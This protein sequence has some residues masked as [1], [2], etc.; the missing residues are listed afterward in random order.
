[1]KRELRQV[2]AVSLAALALIVW[3]ALF[4]IAPVRQI[5][6]WPAD[7]QPPAPAAASARPD[8]ETQAPVNLNTASAEELMT[9]PGIGSAKAAAILADREANGAFLTVLDAARV[10]GISERMIRQW[11]DAVTVGEPSP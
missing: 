6:F 4:L 7:Y 11:G 8:A 10:R 5:G 3:G 1:M 9:L 2:I